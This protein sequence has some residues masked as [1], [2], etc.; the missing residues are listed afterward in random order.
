MTWTVRSL[1]P[2]VIPVNMLAWSLDSAFPSIHWHT[3]SR[4][5]SRRAS[6]LG[7]RLTVHSRLSASR[8]PRR[9]RVDEIGMIGRTESESILHASVRILGQC[10]GITDLTRLEL[11]KNPPLAF[12]RIA[13]APRRYAFLH[14]LAIVS[15]REPSRRESAVLATI[16]E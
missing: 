4:R 2:D 15:P 13:E 10:S 11:E 9:S 8:Q 3:N 16:G 5:A 7:S 1:N 14:S 12:S 6:L